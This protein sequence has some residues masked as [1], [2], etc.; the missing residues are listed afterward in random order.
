MKIKVKSWPFANGYEGIQVE[1]DCKTVDF[2]FE[3]SNKIAEKVY[4]GLKVIQQEL[5]KN[6]QT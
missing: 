6:E 1:S 3:V 2:Y 4:T 5:D